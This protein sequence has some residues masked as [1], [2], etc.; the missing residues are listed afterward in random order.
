MFQAEGGP[1]FVPLRVLLPFSLEETAA[2][3]ESKGERRRRGRRR[4]VTMMWRREKPNK[5]AE[6]GLASISMSNVTTINTYLSR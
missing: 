1:S 5:D 3:A 4:R 2:P 6:G